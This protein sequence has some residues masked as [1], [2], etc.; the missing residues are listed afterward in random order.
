MIEPSAIKAMEFLKK[1][2][3][4]KLTITYQRGTDDPVLSGK[5]AMGI[6]YLDSAKN[7]E[8]DPSNE[9]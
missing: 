6:V 3:D 9:R 8:E 4:E 2:I 5:S 7:I 1:F